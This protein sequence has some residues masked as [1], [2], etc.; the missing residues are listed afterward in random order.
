MFDDPGHGFESAGDIGGCECGGAIGEAGGEEELVGEEGIY[1]GGG[2]SEVGELLP[3]SADRFGSFPAPVPA[4]GC[5]T[6]SVFKFDPEGD[7][8]S[9]FGP[10]EF[11]LIDLITVA[12]FGEKF[13]TGGNG[14]GDE[15]GWNIAGCDAGSGTDDTPAPGPVDWVEG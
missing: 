8:E 12:G 10:G 6:E 4:S 1:G 15:L 11:D 7:T 13:D 14:V 2:I 9:R 5:G 3:C